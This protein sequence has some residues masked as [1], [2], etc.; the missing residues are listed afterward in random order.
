MSKAKA[1]RPF[2]TG[3]HAYGIPTKESDIDVV[4]LM[5]SDLA[6]TLAPFQ[7][8]PID[9][10]YTKF[11]SV[12]LCFGNLNIIACHDIEVWKMWWDGTEHLKKIKPVTREFACRYFDQ[13][14]NERLI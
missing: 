6:M 8:N 13:L 11:R 5:D 14:R 7:D 9:M 4:V 10:D 12:P 3:S 2:I 1:A